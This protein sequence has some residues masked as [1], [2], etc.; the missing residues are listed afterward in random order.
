MSDPQTT[1]I[2]A[3][4]PS[5]GSDTGTWDQPCNANFSVT[6]S[7][8]ANVATITLTSSPVT[9]TT[10]PNSGSAW[11]GP[12]QSQSG[13]LRFTGT[14]G[15]DVT[16]TIPRAGFFI[17]QN[18]CVVGS[19]AVILASAAPG[20]VIGCPPGETIQV[21]CDGVDMDFVAL[22]RVNEYEDWAVS[23]V[24]RW[25]SVCTVP[26]YLNCDGSAFSGTTYPNTAA[27]LGG[28]TLPDSRG[29][30]R[31]A[32]NQTTARITAASGYGIDG[33]TLIASGGKQ[34]IDQET[35]PAVTLT[36][37]IAAGQGSHTHL[38]GSSIT[39]GAT[40]GAVDG[41]GQSSV[42]SAAST[43]PAMTGT[44]PLG[45]SGYNQ[46]PPGYVGGLTVIRAG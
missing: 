3:Y 33:D 25:V 7:L 24:P 28:T 18:K 29:R 42:N 31:F 32:L 44:T 46:L 27:Y 21:F 2:G 17:V 14:L 19:H 22:G 20:N 40:A 8:A 10:P 13:I 16:V 38:I 39:T 23:T 1:N 43:L 34:T 45:G 30:S 36:T 12:Y 15:A 26:P 4:V 9:L 5:R 41:V 37:T 35:L 11:A 6:D